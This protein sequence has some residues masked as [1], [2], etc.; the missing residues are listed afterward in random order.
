MIV[1][2]DGDKS[3]HN[4]NGSGKRVR[5]CFCATIHSLGIGLDDGSGDIPCKYR[6][7]SIG[8]DK[9]FTGRKLG[10][11]AVGQVAIN[12]VPSPLRLGAQL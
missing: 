4:A 6:L 1:N 7:A 11:W 8:Q 12:L 10:V 5:I 2:E 9:V 3:L